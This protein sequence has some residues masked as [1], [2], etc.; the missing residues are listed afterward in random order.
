VTDTI[1]SSKLTMGTLLSGVHQ[2]LTYQ[3]PFTNGNK[4]MLYIM[5]TQFIKNSTSESSEQNKIIIIIK[6]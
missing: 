2:S 4:S 1:L 6:Y 5:V 3:Q